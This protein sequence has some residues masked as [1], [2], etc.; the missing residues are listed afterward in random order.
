MVCLSVLYS[1]VR[2]LYGGN[3]IFDYEVSSALYHHIVNELCVV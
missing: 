1:M 3:D 2:V